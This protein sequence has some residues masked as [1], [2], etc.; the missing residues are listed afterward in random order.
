MNGVRINHL[1]KRQMDYVRETKP[2]TGILIV[3]ETKGNI[4]RNNHFGRKNLEQT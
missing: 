3:L 1:E 4:L 2:I